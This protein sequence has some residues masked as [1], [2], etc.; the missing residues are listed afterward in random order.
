MH[1]QGRRRDLALDVLNPAL[2]LT[3]TNAGGKTLGTPWKVA[4]A[5]HDGLSVN[6]DFASASSFAL[7]DVDADG[8]RFV[9]L[10]GCSTA[11]HGARSRAAALMGCDV[12]MSLA[13][14]SG[15]RRPRLR[16]RLV[17]LVEPR[18]IAAALNTLSLCCGSK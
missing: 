18:S 3:L 17:E 12:L 5:T 2:M 16:A 1:A 8:A 9:G 10:V 6:S 11:A 15:E 13:K 7:F 14:G 4:V